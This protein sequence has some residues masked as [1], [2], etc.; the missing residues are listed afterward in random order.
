M[1]FRGMVADHA[2]MASDDGARWVLPRGFASFMCGVPLGMLVNELSDARP[3]LA[4]TIILTVTAVLS[5]RLL[6]QPKMPIIEPVLRFS[7]VIIVGGFALVAFLPRSASGVIAALTVAVLAGW[8]TL[9]VQHRENVATTL[10]CLSIT[11]VGTVLLSWLFTASSTAEKVAAGFLSLWAFTF[12]PFGLWVAAKSPK[13]PI[14]KP[15]E[16][17]SWNRSWSR[18]GALGLV[19]LPASYG[20][21]VNGDPLEATVLAIGGLSWFGATMVLVLSDDRRGLAGALLVASGFCTLWLVVTAFLMD[22][23]PL[24]VAIAPLGA[25]MFG[26]GIGLLD[27]AGVLASIRQQFVVPRPTDEERQP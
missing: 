7:P 6:L 5:T 23:F 27:A 1:A 17:R 13:R 10:V 20:L 21:A 8:V 11:A 14:F 18:A 15:G 25:A 16:V 19:L 3:Q 22:L 2:R 9:A 12:G 24:G 4:W 26:S